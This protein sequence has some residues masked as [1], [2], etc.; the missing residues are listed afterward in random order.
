MLSQDG[1]YALDQYI[2]VLQQVE[3]LSPVTIRNYVSDLRLFI[4]WCEGFWDGRQENRFFTPQMIAPSLL[5]RYREYLQTMLGL[6]PSTVNRTLMIPP[7]PSN[8]CRKKC[9]LL[10]I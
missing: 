3:D 6:K 9:P 2:Q 10:A 7:V 5:I 1:Q 8:S 4:A